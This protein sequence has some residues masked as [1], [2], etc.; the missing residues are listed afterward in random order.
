MK[1]FLL[2][3]LIALISCRQ[4]E[5]GIIYSTYKN[6]PIN[7]VRVGER[8]QLVFGSNSCCLNGQ[9]DKTTLSSL[10]YEKDSVVLPS[11]EDCAGCTTYYAVIFKAVRPGKDS[12]RFIVKGD[13]SGN[14]PLRDTVDRV[15]DSFLVVVSP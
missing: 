9:L 2:I 15:T 6:K 10:H 12:L 13:P 7:N 1:H 14:S 3:F 11:P 4:A 8:F 5:N